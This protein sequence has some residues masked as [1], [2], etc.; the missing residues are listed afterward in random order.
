L[1]DADQTTAG[2]RLARVIRVTGAARNS[3]A[4]RQFATIAISTVLTTARQKPATV[5]DLPHRHHQIDPK[6]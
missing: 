3:N 4:R 1:R 2:D 5:A 6:R